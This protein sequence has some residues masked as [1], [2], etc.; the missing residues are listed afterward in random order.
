MPAFDNATGG[1][2][3]TRRE[4]NRLVDVWIVSPT[5]QIAVAKPFL[6]IAT[7]T[8]SALWPLSERFSGAPQTPLRETEAW[9][10]YVEF[11]CRTQAATI[12]PFSLIAT[13]GEC[14][15]TAG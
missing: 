15:L 10:S 12:A 9:T 4:L 13:E 6:S 3:P 7:L 11:S 2:Q 5:V 8:S 14:A 1:L